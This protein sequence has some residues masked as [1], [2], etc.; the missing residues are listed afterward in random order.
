MMSFWRDDAGA[1]APDQSKAWIEHLK[2]RSVSFY[3][4]KK[5]MWGY[6]VN[7]TSAPDIN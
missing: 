4:L 2:Q 6:G 7:R 5:G 1:G 3:E